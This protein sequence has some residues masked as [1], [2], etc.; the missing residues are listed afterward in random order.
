MVRSHPSVRR[1]LLG[2]LVTAFLGVTG[3]RGTPAQGT[4]PALQPVLRL[5]TI[6]GY[7]ARGLEE[8]ASASWQFDPS[9][10]QRFSASVTAALNL[11]GQCFYALS[12]PAKPWATAVESRGARWWLEA[13]L[14]SVEADAATFDVKMNRTVTDS[15]VSPNEPLQ[16]EQRIRLRDGGNGILD[17]VRSTS[18]DSQCGSFAVGLGLGFA[19]PSG[20][21]EAGL[22]YDVWLIDRSGDGVERAVRSVSSAR[23][24]ENA[25]FVF[26]P[27][28]FKSDG[29]P[30]EDGR[31]DWR[32]TLSGNIR[33]RVLDAD[34]IDLAVDTQRGFGPGD[35]SG[36][37][38]SAGRKRLLVRAGETVEF[39]MPPADYDRLPPAVRAHRIAIRV[40]TNRLW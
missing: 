38:T 25:G 39:E 9:Q 13:R 19:R 7:T 21:P 10:V 15:D 30:V 24:G 20:A 35:R 22:Q 5:Y 2:V 34:T 1:I 8:S 33:G 27:L 32:M 4:A 3:Q 36:G 6:P 26:R 23:E 12:A 14:V 31:G 17:V 28:P 18:S 37:V 29:T 40:T 11:N 16:I